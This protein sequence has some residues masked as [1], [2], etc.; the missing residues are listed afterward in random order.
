MDYEINKETLIIVPKSET[1]KCL[2]MES[3]DTYDIKNSVSN[4]IKHSCE[5]FGSSYEGRNIGTYKLLGIRHKS[6]I[7]IE[8]SNNIIFFPTE[9]P[10]NDSCYWVSFNNIATFF[11]NREKKNTIVEFK[12]GQKIEIPISFH[13]FSNQYLR[14]SKLKAVISSR[15]TEKIMTRAIESVEQICNITELVEKSSRLE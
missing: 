8:E 7:I 15:K 13:S 5:Y 1:K 11:E 6:P 3:S 9:S 10:K 12:N 2:I 14:A 4:I